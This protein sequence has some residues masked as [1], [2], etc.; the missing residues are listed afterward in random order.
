M[1]A[2]G[3]T[4]SA[5][6]VGVAAIDTLAEL[7]LPLGA[8][9]PVIVLSG[10]AT[11]YIGDFL[12]HGH[13]RF[14]LKTNR[15]ESLLKLGPDLVLPI[16]LVLI[17][18][19]DKFGIGWE[20]AVMLLLLVGVHLPDVFENLVNLKVLPLTEAAKEHRRFHYDRLHWH[21]DPSKSKLPNGARA[22]APVDIYQFALLAFGIY[23]LV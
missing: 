2:L 3:H 21:N 14:N 18:C 7:S 12:P 20:W 5:A 10:V 1:I 9:W 8:V 4:G 17:L 23:L 16:L 19:A 22:L 6:L 13:Y 15:K 11:H